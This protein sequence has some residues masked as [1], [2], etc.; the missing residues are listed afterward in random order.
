MRNFW[1]HLPRL[2]GDNPQFYV[3]LFRDEH[4]LLVLRA[5]EVGV[6]PYEYARLVLVGA[7]EGGVTNDIESRLRPVLDEVRAARELRF[8]RRRH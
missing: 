1:R 5:H 3:P 2:D 4:E 8:G 7:V 6:S